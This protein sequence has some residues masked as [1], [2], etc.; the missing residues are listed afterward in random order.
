MSAFAPFESHLH[1]RMIVIDWRLEPAT[2]LPASALR[3][4]DCWRA[5]PTSGIWLLLDLDNL[6]SVPTCVGDRRASACCEWAWSSG[7]WA[8]SCAED[9]CPGLVQSRAAQIAPVP[10]LHQRLVRE[11]HRLA[12]VPASLNYA[13]LIQPRVKQ[14]PAGKNFRCRKMAAKS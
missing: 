6:A 2:T 13:R 11:M 3:P 10:T 4:C 5:M 14:I 1:H 8:R 7:G 9:R 12:P